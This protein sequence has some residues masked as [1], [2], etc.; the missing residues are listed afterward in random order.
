MTIY[1]VIP[2]IVVQ[3]LEENGD[4]ESTLEETLLESEVIIYLAAL[5]A[6]SDFLLPLSLLR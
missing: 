6:S 4:L 1:Q 3:C 2:L 5:F